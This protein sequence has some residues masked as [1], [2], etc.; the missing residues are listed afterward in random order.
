M[1]FPEARVDNAEILRRVRARFRGSDD[2][3]S[4]LESAIERV[5]AMCGTKVR[6]LEP[7]REARVADYAVE[8]A[9]RCLAANNATLDE[10]DLVICGGIARQ[11]FEPATATEVAAK[12]GFERIHAFD[13]TSACVGHL[14]AIQTAAAYLSLHDEYRTAL[15]CT[16]ELSGD[17]L[18]YDL[19]QVKDLYMKSAGLTIGN[20]AACVLLRKTPWPGGGIRLRGIHT[21]AA[22]DHWHLCQVPID[23]TLFSSSVELMRLGKTIP[24]LL[25]K[26]LGQV[27][28]DPAKVE[29]YV[30]HQP[31][32]A[33]VRRILEDI[34]ADPERGVYTHRFY[35]NTASASVGVTYEHLL[36]DRAVKQ[37]DK[38]VLGSAAAGFS[39]VIATG[40]WT[41]AQ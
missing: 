7:N 24:P 33:I 26:D 21:H 11:Y 32:E 22:P 17:Y 35:G 38:I 27:G 16:S 28:F 4:T 40:E 12:L 25:Q 36:K 15:V 19:Q 9:K 18:S 20:A 1:T 10:I 29:H 31:S 41:G 14:E 13:V 37:G 23:G 34:G 6:Y 8:A 3:W 2:D 5:F 30:F 39:V